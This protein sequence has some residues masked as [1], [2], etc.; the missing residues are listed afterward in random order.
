MWDSEPSEPEELP[1]PRAGSRAAPNS[2]RSRWAELD[3]RM[4]GD[5]EDSAQYERGLNFRGAAPLLALGIFLV[6]YAVVLSLEEPA[7]PGGHLAI[8]ELVVAAGAVILGAGVFSLFLAES[9][10]EEKAPGAVPRRRAE[11]EP[12]VVAQPRPASP[13]GRRPT[14]TVLPG[15]ARS[16]FA[17]SQ[18]SP[19]A[20]LPPWW[21][22]PPKRTDRPVHVAPPVSPARPSAP[23]A[24]PVVS[25][26]RPYSAVARSPTP[27]PTEGAA[28]S[29]GLPVDIA[30]ALAAWEA[31]AKSPKPVYAQPPAEL[32]RHRPDRC[33]DCNRTLDADPGARGCRSCGRRLCTECS[34]SA[35][36]SARQVACIDCLLRPI[37]P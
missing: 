17:A 23:P 7:V 16:A 26:A 36:Q 37:P 2:T 13:P 28:P 4:P 5:E 24:H 19:R 11:H 31:I 8:W 10:A 34:S 1:V 18:T 15:A 14:P 30:D 6:G 29:G 20:E 32:S 27:H 12:L 33:V 22:G 35:L 9:P 3:G 25:R 21:E